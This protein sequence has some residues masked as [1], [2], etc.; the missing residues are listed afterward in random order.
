V[1][2]KA[3]GRHLWRVLRARWPEPHILFVYALKVAT[4]YHYA[5]ITRALAQVEDGSSVLPN[6]GRSF[7]R[8]KRRVDV[9]AAA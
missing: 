2:N 1:V 7:S 6:A 9:Q 5:A 4:H 3:Y 8:V